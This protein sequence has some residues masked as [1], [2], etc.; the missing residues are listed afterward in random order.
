MTR[1][2]VPGTLFPL[3]FVS[4]TNGCRRPRGRQGGCSSSKCYQGNVCTNACM[5]HVGAKRRATRSESMRTAVLVT[6]SDGSSC[7]SEIRPTEKIHQH[8]IDIIH[9]RHCCVNELTHAYISTSYPITGIKPLLV[10]A[11]SHS[12]PH[13]D[14]L[15][16][17]LQHAE[18]RYSIPHQH[19]QQSPRIR[20]TETQRQKRAVQ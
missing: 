10:P 13:P 15:R 9:R 19:H 3:L 16:C 17:S 5:Q 11:L 20:Q 12:H 18:P 7:A 8:N 6:A 14:L 2:K 4:K 1:K